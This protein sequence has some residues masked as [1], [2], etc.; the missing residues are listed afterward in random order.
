MA[1]FQVSVTAFGA[2]GE[3]LGAVRQIFSDAGDDPTVTVNL[4]EAVTTARLTVAVTDLTDPAGARV[5]VRDIAVR[6]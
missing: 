5:H 3:Q 1:E 2:G 4:P 6:P